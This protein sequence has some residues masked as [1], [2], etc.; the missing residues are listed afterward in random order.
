MGSPGPWRLG[1]LLSIALL[2]ARVIATE[3]GQPAFLD[4]DLDLVWPGAGTWSGSHVRPRWDRA[5]ER[6]L[7]AAHLC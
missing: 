4:L 3:H 7:R 2:F 6:P 1:P 5:P